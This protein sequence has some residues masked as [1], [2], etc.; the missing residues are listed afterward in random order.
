MPSYFGLNRR[1]V[2]PHEILFVGKLN[3][4]K[5]VFELAEAV[6]EVF[7]VMSS[8]RLV[9]IGGDTQETGKSTKEEFLRRIPSA[10]SY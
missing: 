4:L 3:A 1:I 8:A 5:G 9:M 10:L 7:Q 6:T 2:N